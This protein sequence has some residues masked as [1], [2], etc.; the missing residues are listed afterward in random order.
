MNPCGLSF[1]SVLIARLPSAAVNPE[2]DGEV[3]GVGRGV[4]I[5]RPLLVR[6]A[7]VWDVTFDGLGVCGERKGQHRENYGEMFHGSEIYQRAGHPALPS[8]QRTP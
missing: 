6:L 1:T 5:Q 8:G 3:L 7:G 2:D 4:D